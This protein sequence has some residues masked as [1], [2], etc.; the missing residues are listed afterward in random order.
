MK[1]VSLDGVLSNRSFGNVYT[2]ERIADNWIVAIKVCK[3]AKSLIQQNQE[4]SVLE[5]CNSEFIVRY[6]DVFVKDDTVWVCLNAW[7][8]W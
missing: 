8:D 4:G 5:S 2:A 6:E 3:E 1:G 7:G